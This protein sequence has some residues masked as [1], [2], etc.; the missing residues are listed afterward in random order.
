MTEAES[1]NAALA[2]LGLTFICMCCFLVGGLFINAQF[3]HGEAS[4]A[5]NTGALAATKAL[6]NVFKADITPIGYAKLDEL[7]QE[8][9]ADPLYAKGEQ[10]A[11][12]IRHTVPSRLQDELLAGRRG[13]AVSLEALLAYRPFFSEQELGRLLYQ[14]FQIHADM[15]IGSEVRKYL[16]EN[17]AESVCTVRFPV[18]GRIEVEARREMKAAVFDRY[19]QGKVQYVGGRGHALFIEILDAN[20]V[21][22][23]ISG[24]PAW[25]AV[26]D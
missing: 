23:D 22:Y 15:Q 5:A 8:L 18:H 26:F 13:A 20:G 7:M 19:L 17:N 1:G 21:S 12:I 6:E 11:A 4:A 14:S 24:L 9:T 10:R 2:L 25:E 3:A 16:A